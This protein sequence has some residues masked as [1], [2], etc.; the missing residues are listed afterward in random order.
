[1]DQLYARFGVGHFDLTHDLF[2]VNRRKIQ[3]FCVAVDGSPYTWSCSARVDCVDRALLE[4]MHASGL[5]QIYFGIETGS[6]RLQRVTDKRLD[7]GLVRPIL[8]VTRAL[9]IDATLSF[10]TG[11]PE[12]EVSDQIETLDFMTDCMDVVPTGSVQ[13][14]VLTPEPGTAL[15]TKFQH[16]LAYDGES[17]DF[18]LPILDA[19]DREMILADPIVFMN[20][21]YYDAPAVP[22]R[23]S[24]FVAGLFQLLHRLGRPLLAYWSRFHDGHF[25]RAVSAVFEWAD[26]GGHLDEPPAELLLTFAEE[27]YGPDHHLPSL[28]KYFLTADVLVLRASTGSA[29]DRE[30]AAVRADSELGA[31]TLRLGETVAWFADRH[32]IIEMLATLPDVAPNDVRG[33]AGDGSSAYLLVADARAGSVQNI[34]LSDAAAA[35]LSF[36]EQPRRVRDCLELG[37]DV[38]DDVSG[39]RSYVRTC[40]ERGILVP[41]PQRTM[42]ESEPIASVQHGR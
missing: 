32:H 23:R 13:L 30:R 6:R 12:E 20:Y 14:H 17:S 16:T 37:A 27:V 29:D 21:Y 5:R 28:F 25:G 15:W 24:L 3:E 1:M 22:H 4:Q 40:V 38:L 35:V 36:F 39:L 26:A 33:G 7:L 19:H 18:G 41:V 10:I 2:T 9:D 42:E 34:A 31:M 8:E 11:F